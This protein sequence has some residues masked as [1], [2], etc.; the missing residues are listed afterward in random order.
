MTASSFAAPPARDYPLRM[1]PIRILSFAALAAL[2]ACGVPEA[3]LRSGLIN[4]GI[5]PRMAGCMAD[6]MAHRLS[7]AQL[8]RLGDLPH[9]RHDDSVRDYLHEV[10]AL[11]DPEIVSVTSSAAARCALHL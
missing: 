8:R 1:R 2:A 9:V 7:I 5:H 11:R 10:R 4:A 6:H 3:R